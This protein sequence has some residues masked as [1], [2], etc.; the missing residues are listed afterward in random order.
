MILGVVKKKLFHYARNMVNSIFLNCW[1]IIISYISAIYILRYS[2]V[3]EYVYVHYVELFSILY[4]IMWE[5]SYTITKSNVSY[6]SNYKIF[7]PTV[8][9]FAFLVLM[10]SCVQC[11]QAS[12]AAWRTNNAIWLNNNAQF[13]CFLKA[14]RVYQVFFSIALRY[15]FILF[16]ALYLATYRIYIQTINYIT[17]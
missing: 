1:R 17:S 4:L 11:P 5:I 9:L 10:T 3:I 8:F 16:P 13:V 12:H 14:F 2:Y 6:I 15:F 7:V